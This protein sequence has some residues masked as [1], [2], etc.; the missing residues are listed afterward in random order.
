MAA[1][2]GADRVYA[3]FLAL[4]V[5][6]RTLRATSTAGKMEIAEIEVKK[7]G[8]GGQGVH[9]HM[10]TGLFVNSG[11]IEICGNLVNLR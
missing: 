11:Q 4:F 5:T 1:K 10:N 7:K 9:G 2:C 3:T 6:R 8:P